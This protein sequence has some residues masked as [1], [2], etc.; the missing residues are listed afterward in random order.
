MITSAQ[1]EAKW[2]DN[3]VILYKTQSFSDACRVLKGGFTFL[4]PGRTVAGRELMLLEAS[5]TIRPAC[6][7]TSGG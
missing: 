4:I 7:L 3:K 2:V 6:C 1:V 5:L